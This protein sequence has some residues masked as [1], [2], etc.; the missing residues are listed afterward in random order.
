MTF[1]VSHANIWLR[2]SRGELDAQ[3][4]HEFS[5]ARKPDSISDQNAAELRPEVRPDNLPTIPE[6][7][8]MIEVG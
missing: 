4:H 8:S 3:K 2:G 7:A 6:I 5:V 1:P